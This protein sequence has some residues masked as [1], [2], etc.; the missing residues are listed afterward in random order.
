MLLKELL[1]DLDIHTGKGIP[2]VFAENII[3]LAL[4]LDLILYY[5]FNR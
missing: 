1:V 2:P 4:S 5:G 3:S